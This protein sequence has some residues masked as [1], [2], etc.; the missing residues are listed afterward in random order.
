MTALK[1]KAGIT[2]KRKIAEHKK[3]VIY[4][5]QL[6]IL[7]SFEGKSWDNKEAEDRGSSEIFPSFAGFWYPA[8]KIYFISVS[9]T[10]LGTSLPPTPNWSRFDLFLNVYSILFYCISSYT[11]Y[12]IYCIFTCCKVMHAVLLLLLWGF[13]FP[14]QFFAITLVLV[15]CVFF[16]V[17][18]EQCEQCGSFAFQSCAAGEA[19]FSYVLRCWFCLFSPLFRVYFP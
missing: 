4:P 9:G 6:F 18:C 13:V 19:S 12:F 10:F 7:G 16:A 11:L 2:R 3:K 1:T 8:K 17:V 14:F 15:W 5:L